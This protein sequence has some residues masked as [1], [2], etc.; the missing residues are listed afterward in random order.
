[1]EEF[2]DSSA[3]LERNLKAEAHTAQSVYESARVTSDA[4]QAALYLAIGATN[5]AKKKATQTN[6]KA[7]TARE[8]ANKTSAAGG[9]TQ[10]RA[11]EKATQAESVARAAKEALELANVNERTIRAEKV[12]A[13]EATAE[14]RKINAEAERAMAKKDE[15]SRAKTLKTK[16][17]IAEVIRRLSKEEFDMYEEEIRRLASEHTPA[18]IV[19]S[20]KNS[21]R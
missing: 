12:R 14:A 5:A 9:A 17:V 21:D 20:I 8:N 15:E 4:T 2:Q 7:K 3:T 11:E 10:T 13:D 16:E 1:M 6:K 19:W 18:F